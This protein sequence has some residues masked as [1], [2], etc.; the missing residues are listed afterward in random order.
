MADTLTEYPNRGLTRWLSASAKR[1]SALFLLVMVLSGC[2]QSARQPVT[3]SSLL[4]SWSQPDEFPTEEALSRQFTQATSIR[5][6]NFPVPENTLDQL[7]LSRRLLEDGRAGPDVVGIDLIWSGALGGDLID[8]RSNLAAEISSLEPQ[9]VP[10]LIEDGSVVAIPY[11]VELGVLE[12]RT[13][14]LREYGYKYP[15]KTWDELESM[16]ER[17]QAGER[18]KGK[19]EQLDFHG[20]SSRARHLCGQG[21]APWLF[22]HDSIA[23]R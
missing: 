23:V 5:V 1:A 18:N 7:S 17:I 11:Q 2:R 4:P 6:N 13:D 16:A 15:P 3:L 21:L 22:R 14:L 12:Y 19:T 20:F 9:F 8:L 10:S